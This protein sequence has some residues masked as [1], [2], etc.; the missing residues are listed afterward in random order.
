[1]GV[2][3]GVGEGRRWKVEVEAKEGKRVKKERLEQQGA[4]AAV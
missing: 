3:V 1:V 4:R 2:G